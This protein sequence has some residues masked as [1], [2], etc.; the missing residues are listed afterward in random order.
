MNSRLYHELHLRNLTIPGNILAAPMA[1]YTDRVCR[2]LAL[3]GGADLAWTEMISAEALMRL[4]VRTEGMMKR[5]EGE[6]IL[7]V[8]LFGSDPETLGRAAVRA[9]ELG[10]D[11]LDLNAG[12]PVPKVTAGGAGAALARDPQKIEASV[13]AMKAAGLPVGVKIRSGWDEAELNWKDAAMAAVNGGADI[14][15]FHPRTRR[16]GYGGSSDW[17]LITALTALVDL[18]VIGSGDLNSPEDARNM[19]RSTGCAGV[20]FARGGIGDPGIYR[21]TRRL[22]SE[23]TAA[24]APGKRQ[25]LE[26]ARHHLSMAANA[27]G[28]EK[29]AREIKK[30][31]AGYVKGWESAADFRNRLVRSGGYQELQSLLDAAIREETDQT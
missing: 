4:S 1:G 22:L 31:L 21:R 29:T 6:K 15:G 18:P 26:N 23:G 9:A 13:T 30:H 19:L 10:A 17:S 14:L 28:E 20:M 25:R 8:Q 7:A 16:Q 11:I 3:E 12:C 27:F 5:A 24:A 2:A